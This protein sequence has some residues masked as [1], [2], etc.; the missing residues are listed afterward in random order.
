MFKWRGILGYGAYFLLDCF[1][2][3][4]KNIFL[5]GIFRSLGK[6]LLSLFLSMSLL[7]VFAVYRESMIDIG[8]NRYSI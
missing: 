7:N 4:S 5:I 8:R 3:S 1:A 2:G 6:D